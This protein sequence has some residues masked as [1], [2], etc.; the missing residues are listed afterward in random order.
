MTSPNPPSNKKNRDGMVIVGSVVFVTIFW[1]LIVAVGDFPEFILPSPTTVILRFFQAVQGGQLYRHI[2]TTVLEVLL[3]L[4]AGTFA[5]IFFGFLLSRN[6]V[7]DQLLS[8]V[9]VASQAVPV[10]AI[11]PLL[12]IWF[13]NGMVSK[14]LVCALIIFFP[15]LVNILLG[16]K[17]IPVELRDLMITFR[18]NRWQIFR[19]LEVPATLP[20]F[21]GGMRVGA[22]LS[23][24]GAVV[25]EF[26]GAE[27]GLGFMIN[28]ARGQY[29]TALV[30][31]VII[32]LIA[33]AL[34]LYNLIL[35]LEKLLLRW[36]A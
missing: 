10:V 3:G 2:L 14:V 16:L 36:K 25:G 31:V 1:Y 29:D 28:V 6:P 24:T 13:G 20:F 19:H 21:L 32:I 17:S 35:L 23:V 4:S 18:A 5:A 15:V 26:L 11:A 12:V 30:F 27:S 34:L 9:L 33:L 7:I 22:T 8:P